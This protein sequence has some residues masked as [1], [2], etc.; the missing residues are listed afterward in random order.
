[1]STCK[2]PSSY[3]TVGHNAHAL[4]EFEEVQDRDD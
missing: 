3:P 4:G 2:I 1:M